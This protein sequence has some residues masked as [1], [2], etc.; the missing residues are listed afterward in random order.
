M[1]VLRDCEGGLWVSEWVGVWL[2]DLVGD[3]GDTVVRVRD[4]EGEPV[5]IDQEDWVGLKDRVEVLV[6]VWEAL[7]AAERLAEAVGVK[8]TGLREAVAVD[9]VSVWLPWVQDAV[10]DGEEG[11]AVGELLMLTGVPV[12][13]MEHVGVTDRVT[14]RL[15]VKTGVSVW[16]WL[17]ADG[18][19][20]R[21]TV[22]TVGVCDAVPK[23][24]VVAEGMVGVND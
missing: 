20:V 11:V 24:M 5:A 15:S 21:V 12:G 17:G 2:T 7:R 1:G 19:R 16:V 13:S 4:R 23:D 3:P 9:T 14:V 10:R 6:G 18:V 22:E 8:D